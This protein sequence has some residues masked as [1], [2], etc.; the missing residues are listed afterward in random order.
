MKRY[1][2]TR[3]KNQTKEKKTFIGCVSVFRLFISS[4]EDGFQTV[5]L[6]AFYLYLSNFSPVYFYGIFVS[7]N[8]WQLRQLDKL[9]TQL[10]SSSSQAMCPCTF[11]TGVYIVSCIVAYSCVC[12]CVYSCKIYMRLVLPYYITSLIWI[13]QNLFCFMTV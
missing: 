3:T 1:K 4:L 8:Y 12:V 5:T 10:S 6:W 11:I 7:W 2:N 9:V 13:W